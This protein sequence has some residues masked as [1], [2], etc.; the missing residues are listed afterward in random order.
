MILNYIKNAITEHFNISD[1]NLWQGGRK[2]SRQRHL[3]FYIAAQFTNVSL[4]KIGSFPGQ[5]GFKTFDHSSV[6]YGHTKITNNLD[7]YPDETVVV[8]TLLNNIKSNKNLAIVNGV[9]V[10]LDQSKLSQI[11]LIENE[12]EQAVNKVERLKSKYKNLTGA[13]WVPKK[14]FVYY[15]TVC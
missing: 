15:Q 5:D 11:E 6:H 4:K 1:R 13:E 14:T 7:I 8:N 2:T 9:I 3:F 10:V 12:L